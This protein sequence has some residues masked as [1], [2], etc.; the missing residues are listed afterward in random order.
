MKLNMMSD[1]FVNELRDLYDAE[2]RLVKALPKMAKAATRPE[3]R[4]GF[5][6]HLQ[7]TTNHVSRL[8]QAFEAL[9]MKPKARKCDAMKGLVEEGAD[10]IDAG[11]DD[12]DVRDAGL[13][14]AAQKVEHY[15]IASYGTLI[16]WARELG[17]T[18][19]AD[20]L[21]QTLQEEKA[22]D[23]R[24]TELAEARI[25]R[26]AKKQEELQEEEAEAGQ[27]AVM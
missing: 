6:Q 22:T 17:H 10:I 3:L 9:N 19:I 1:L 15:E 24:L 21:S 11:G 20:L 2:R 16:A 23:R 7:E 25:N 18:Q 5:E 26:Q 27:P 4:Q 13:I 14:C 12:D 8:E